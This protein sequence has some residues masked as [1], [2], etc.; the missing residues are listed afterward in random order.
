M[1]DEIRQVE[2]ELAG[3]EQWERIPDDELRW[4]EAIRDGGDGTWQVIISL[5]QIPLDD[6]PI[7]SDVRGGIANAL[8]A[9]PG[10]ES[11]AEEDQE[12]WVVVGNPMGD[13]LVRAAATLVDTLVDRVRAYGEG[14]P[15]V[16]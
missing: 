9:V 4:V 12:V 1:S 11:V 14:W 10:V 13:E 8:R 6:E 5:A 2:A 3:D 7:R 16:E 15:A